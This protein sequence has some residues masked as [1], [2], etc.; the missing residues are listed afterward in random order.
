MIRA[1]VAGVLLCTARPDE[2]IRGAMIEAVR[3]RGTVLGRAS[4]HDAASITGPL[5]QQIR[6]TVNF[7]RLNTR[8]A[9]RKDPGTGGDP[10][11][12]SA[13]GV[14]GHRQRRGSPRLLNGEC[15][16]TALYL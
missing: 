1:T 11:I 2:H 3:Y 14:R 7:A 5:D 4:Q 8:V 15:E 9:A 12:Q 10:A 13:G 16:D 6:D